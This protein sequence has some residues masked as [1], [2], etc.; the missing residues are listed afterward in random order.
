MTKKIWIIFFYNLQ[1]ISVVSLISIGLP[2]TLYSQ[3]NWPGEDNLSNSE[4]IDN[5]D[6]AN[7]IDFGQFEDEDESF[8]NEKEKIENAP[9]ELKN[10]LDEENAKGESKT[11]Q[12][13]HIVKDV[14]Q[15]IKRNNFAGV[16]YIEGGRGELAEGEAPDEYVIAKGDNLFDICDQLLGDGSYWPKLW[17][18]NRFIKNPHFLWPGM[19]IRFFAGDEDDPPFIEVVKEENFRPLVKDETIGGGD[20]GV[21]L[22]LPKEKKLLN[23]EKTEV[24]DL[25]EFKDKG[26]EV[27][28]FGG[29]SGGQNV[30]VTLPGFVEDKILTPHCIVKGGV[31]GE[32]ISGEGRKFLCKV[33]GELQIQKTYTVVRKFKMFQKNSYE[34]QVI[35]LYQY[36]GNISFERIINNG[37]I[38]IGIVLK[39]RL[40]VI[41]G[42]EV[43]PYRS[44]KRK[45]N[46]TLQGQFSN[47]TVGEILSFGDEGRSVGGQGQLAFIN[48]GKGTGIQ[49]GQLLKIKQSLKKY[50]KV[51]DVDEHDTNLVD[52][53]VM[54]IIDS[55][56]K[57][58]IGYIVSVNSEVTLGDYIMG[59]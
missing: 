3:E 31:K 9:D 54:R 26:D 12:G 11:N 49:E 5:T 13:D 41:E 39:N 58:S 21:E 8:N 48:R 25:S 35:F 15:P 43:I 23:D 34:S 50:V 32:Y 16:P 20:I 29:F 42:D 27:E 1:I 37:T 2:G 24:L 55:T 45:V 36:V 51:I 4:K 22:I 28:Y 59:Q 30:D 57:G 17:S 52:I 6:S 53:G 56:E 14:N 44:T 18:L 19:R 33:A 47:A 7:N 40:A 46:L 38:A 10:V